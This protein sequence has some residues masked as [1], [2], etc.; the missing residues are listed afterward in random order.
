M[1]TGS[2]FLTVPCYVSHDRPGTTKYSDCP[3]TGRSSARA[4]ACGMPSA[5]LVG[6]TT[7]ELAKPPASQK[8]CCLPAAGRLQCETVMA[9]GGLGLVSSLNAMPRPESPAAQRPRLSYD[10]VSRHKRSAMDCTNYFACDIAVMC[11]HRDTLL[12]FH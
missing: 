6:A 12:V 10:K 11:H 7:M 4:A 5:C 3:T 2:L 8:L 9:E 1:G